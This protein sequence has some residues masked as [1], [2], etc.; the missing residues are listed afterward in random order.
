MS[1]ALKSY[2]ANP[3]LLASPEANKGIHQPNQP[4]T[5]LPNKAATHL[6]NKGVIRLSKDMTKAILQLTVM[7][8][9]SRALEMDLGGDRPR[10]QDLDLRHAAVETDEI[11][12][13][14]LAPV[15]AR[16]DVG[17]SVEEAEEGDRDHAPDRAPDL[18][19][20]VAP[21]S[22]FGGLMFGLG[23]NRKIFVGRLHPKV[24]WQLVWC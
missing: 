10:G 17:T 18:E 8:R 1:F 19:D 15:H 13:P 12:A 6:H 3:Y 14:A 5:H 9:H 2:K 11:D 4:A 21:T 7:R 16:G 23:G 20:E 24:A 22:V